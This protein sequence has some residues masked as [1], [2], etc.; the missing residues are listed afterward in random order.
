M[1]SYPW[2]IAN[3]NKKVLVS[4]RISISLYSLWPFLID[5]KRWVNPFTSKLYG[6]FIYLIILY[7]NI[8]ACV[9]AH[10]HSLCFSFWFISLQHKI[11]SLVV[12][13]LF[14]P[15]WCRIWNFTVCVTSFLK[16]EKF[17]SF[18]YHFKK[19]NQCQGQ[20]LCLNS[21]QDSH[22]YQQEL[23]FKCC[24]QWK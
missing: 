3:Y 13:N 16:R 10:T 8:H 14:I 24:F 22:W 15:K 5:K 20:R 4:V 23:I 19:Q 12:F 21:I 11:R 9:H 6:H 17:F 7:T 1:C 18:S 2:T